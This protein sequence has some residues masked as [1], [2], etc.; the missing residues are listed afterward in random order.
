[1]RIEQIILENRVL[2]NT[3]LSAKITAA[4]QKELRNDTDSITADGW[5]FIEEKAPQLIAVKIATD[6]DANEFDSIDDRT[7]TD[8]LSDVIREYEQTHANIRYH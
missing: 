1:M 7:I 6:F 5:T 4:V 8:Y 3:G 2:E